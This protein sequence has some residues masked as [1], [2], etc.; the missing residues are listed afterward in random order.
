[1]RMLPQQLPQGLSTIRALWSKCPHKLPEEQQQQQQSL[2]G[3]PCCAWAPSE[4][5]GGQQQSPEHE[6]LSA[7][8][9]SSVTKAVQEAGQAQGPLEGCVLEEGCMLLHLVQL[10]TE[11]AHA[12]VGQ[13]GVWVGPCV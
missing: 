3:Q 1:M 8:Q 4:L 2:L 7:V 12:A 6:H 10:W 13:P 9:L 11:E 5:A